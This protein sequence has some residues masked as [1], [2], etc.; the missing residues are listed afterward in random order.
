MREIVWKSLFEEGWFAA[1]AAGRKTLEQ[2]RKRAEWLE[3]AL[4][5]GPVQPMEEVRAVWRPIVG[6]DKDAFMTSIASFVPSQ[7]MAAMLSQIWGVVPA[8]RA[9]EAPPPE[10]P[11]LPTEKRTTPVV[12]YRTWH[13]VDNSHIAAT[14]FVGAY[15]PEPFAY[16]GPEW[17]LRSPVR[18]T[19]WRGPILR[20]PAPPALYDLADPRSRGRTDRHHGIYAHSTPEWGDFSK[21]CC[22]GLGHNDRPA[23]GQVEG[24][25]RVVLHERGWRAQNVRIRALLLHPEMMDERT[26]VDDLSRKYDCLVTFNPVEWKKE[27]H[28]HR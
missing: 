12:G 11:P 24:W 27:C 3:R 2:L 9:P 18:E 15:E 1:V 28:G 21:S 17:I 5:D 23:I 6:P 10:P 14:A 26:V 16:Y 4:I 20:A 25:G 19:V 8:A 7:G 13:V 22:C